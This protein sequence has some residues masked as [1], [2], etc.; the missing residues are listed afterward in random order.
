MI[1]AG[2]KVLG[3]ITLGKNARIGANAVV[4]REV[5]ANSVVVGVPGR[6]VRQ[7]GEKLR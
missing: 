2:A 5:P 1:G 3:S 4:I 6:V 7:D